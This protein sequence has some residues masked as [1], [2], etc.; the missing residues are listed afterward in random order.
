MKNKTILKITSGVLSGVVVLSGISQLGR[1][2]VQAKEKIEVK[3]NKDLQ[4]SIKEQNGGAVVDIIAVRDVNNVDVKITIDGKKV[5]SYRVNSLKAGQKEEKVISKEQLEN[6]K[7][8]LKNLANKRVLPNT[9]PVK[10]NIESK[11]NIAGSEI[12]VEVTYY[13]EEEINTEDGRKEDPKQPIEPNKPS[14][15]D[16][17][18]N[19]ITPE[20]PSKPVNPGD[21]DQEVIINDPLLKKLINKN[22]DAARDDNQKITKSEIEKLKIIKL[23]DKNNKAILERKS[24]KGTQDFKFVFTC[25]IKD[26]SGL[27]KAI[28]LE[29]LNLDENEIT[30]LTPL[31]NL[32]KLKHLSLFRNRI[33]NL[34][35]LSDLTNLEFLDLYS[36]KLT[37]ISS[38]KNLVNLKHLDLHNNNDQTGDESHPIV[39]GGIKDI[40]AVAN[41]TKLEVLSLGSNDISDISVLTGLTNIKELILGGNHIKDYSK[42]VDYIVPRIVKMI[43]E[44]GGSIKFD[45]QKINYG[46]EVEVNS[47]NVSMSSPFVGINEIGRK[48]AKQLESEEAINFFSDIKTNVEGVSATYNVATS[49]FELTF[50]DEFLKQNNGKTVPVNLK[51]G[52]EEYAWSLTNI[53]IKVNKKTENP[54]VN[55]S[56]LRNKLEILIK[57][58]IR[59]EEG[60]VPNEGNQPNNN[61]WIE[62]RTKAEQVLADNKATKEQIEQAITSL[63]EATYNAILGSEKVKARKTLISLGKFELIPQITKAT[64]IEKVKKIV[65]DVKG[66]TEEKPAKPDEKDPKKPGNNDNKPIEPEQPV[67]PTPEQPTEKAVITGYEISNKVLES[68]GGSLDVVIKGKNLTVDNVR[69]KV[70]DPFTATKNN[71][72]TDG[73]V[74]KKVGDNIIATINVPS[75]NENNA[76]SYNLIFAD[77]N[78]QKVTTTYEEGRGENGRVITVL[79]V[80]KTKQDAVLSFVTISSYQAHH[81][82]DLTTTT[83]DKGNVSKKNGCSSL[84]Y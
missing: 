13:A 2:D 81:S 9:A 20:D 56:E 3:A 68:N 36:N 14:E 55:E 63:E 27:E 32:K 70:L 47:K 1:I 5:I 42:V 41:M 30:D 38:L 31:A 76:K 62:V 72:L 66:G 17:P 28:N 77:K 69:I 79:P 50:T 78:G 26:L 49:N 51:L 83:T 34:A 48:L 53:K 40:S 61:K 10:K 18:D 71:N 4:I 8:Q 12:K 65:S 52:F 74:Y 24:L 43:N 64:T 16:K 33:T 67:K 75:N 23:R 35:P 57:R 25:G 54:V 19:P 82:T 45:G 58:D 59:S 7:R 84:W 80:G 11:A 37:D 73:I 21:Q 44:E 39:S 6:F 29:E 22:I 60:Y 15:Q 46:K